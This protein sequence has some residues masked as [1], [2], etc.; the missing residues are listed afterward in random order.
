LVKKK[1]EES[2][3]GVG[4]GAAKV[5]TREGER[6]G[7]VGG[8]GVAHAAVAGGREEQ[9]ELEPDEEQ[10]E[11]GRGESG[12]RDGHRIAEVGGTMDGLGCLG[13]TR[14][15]ERRSLC[16]TTALYTTTTQTLT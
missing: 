14:E 2:G 1:K 10:R 7:V 16:L 11:R 3:G 9:L 4:V 15:R 6:G 13:E 5:P 8:L 12:R